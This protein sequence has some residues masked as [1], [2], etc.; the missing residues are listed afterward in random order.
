MGLLD[1]YILRAIFGS[2]GLV[3]AVLLVLG[4]LFTFISQQD[5]IGVGRFSAINALWFT[6]LT[7]PQQAY[8]VLPVGAMLGSLLGMGALARGSELTV[9]R[10]SGVS[11]GRIAASV[12]MSAV[13]LIVLEIALGEF[14]APTLQLVA[15][16]QKAF[17]KFTD[18]TVGSSGGSW[19]R[20]GDLILNV[21]RQSSERQF[22]GML[23]FELSPNHRLRAIGRATQATA[24][25]EANKG[26]TLSGY[27]ESRFTRDRV[28][29]RPSTQRSLQ[30]NVSAGFLGL[31][32]AD[33]RQLETRVLFQLIRYYQSNALDTRPY[34]FAFWSRISRVV[35]IAFSVLLAIPF[36]LGSMRASGTG[37]RMMIGLLIG[38]G[39]FLL[40]RLIES[41]TVVFDLNPIILAWA[42]TVLLAGITVTL[43]ARAR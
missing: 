39:Y 10:S 21:S 25:A 16:Q 42:P 22:A 41:G 19:V 34:V 24:E 27:Q 11:I 7:T 9:M 38:V 31:A 18:V 3:M 37:A 20:D 29:T 6:L 1:R 26:W 15:K 17:D 2:T 5:D 35:A 23:I 30:S 43:L 14:F 36:V 32:V 8:E 12:L 40:Q 33:P 28:L 13:V 4:A